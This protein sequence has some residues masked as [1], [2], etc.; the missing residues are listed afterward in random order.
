MAVTTKRYIVDG[1]F[2]ELGLAGYIFNLSGDDIMSVLRQLDGLVATWEAQGLTIGWVF[3]TDPTTSTPS[4]EVIIP[5][6]ALQALTV[7]LAVIVA[8][9]HGKQISIDTRGNAI[10]SL[11][12]LRSYVV[13]IPKMQYPDNLPLG[14]GNKNWNTRYFMPAE[15]ITA[16]SQELDL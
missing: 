10:R 3:S 2:N 16:N 8:P 9:S 13:S 15:S 12:A 6:S 11:N 1:A 14:Q 5:D 4:S 7:N